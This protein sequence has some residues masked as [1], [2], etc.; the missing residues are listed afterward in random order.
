MA[1]QRSATVPDVTD[2]VEEGAALLLAF[3]SAQV[4]YNLR[5]CSPNSFV[6]VVVWRW[7]CSCIESP[8]AI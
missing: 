6:L 8:H 4:R 7:Y 2:E 5:F 3:S 1:E